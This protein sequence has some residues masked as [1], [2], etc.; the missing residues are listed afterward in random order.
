[1][2][3]SIASPRRTDPPDSASR[4]YAAGLATVL[5][6]VVVALGW[7]GEDW[8]AQLYR[9]ELFR[10]VGFVQWDNGWFGGHYL[11]RYSVLFPPLGGILGVT[12]VVLLSSAAATW[13][14]ADIAMRVLPRRSQ[15]LAIFWFA[16]GSVS[17]VLVGRATFALGLAFALA[18]VAALVRGSRWAIVGAVLASLAS[19][20]AGV[21][22]ALAA[23][24]SW[25]VDRRWL[26]ALSGA[27]ALAPLAVLSVLF[28]EG[29]RF[30]YRGGHFTITL[31]VCAALVLFAPRRWRTLRVGVVLYALAAVAIF[32]V[33]NPLGGNWARLAMFVGGP[34]LAGA[35]WPTRRALFVLLAVPFCIWQWQPAYDSVV[36]GGHDPS[37]RAEYFDPLL[38]FLGR[39]QALRIEIPFT[40]RHWETRY[41]APHVALARGWERQADIEAN[42]IFYAEELR[43]EDYMAWLKDNGVS[44]VALPDVDLDHAAVTEAELLRAGVPGLELVW[45]N[46]NW[47][48]W[49][50]L[51]AR[52]M[53]DGPADL[54]R[55]GA[56]SFTVRLHEPGTALVR[57]RHS[58]H[59]TVDQ[60]GCVAAAANGWTLVSSPAPG[61]LEVRQN[62]GLGASSPVRCTR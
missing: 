14:F 16:V 3:A 26:P 54:V 32:V 18:A 2:T 58:A 50:V 51:D 25:L 4:W 62:I 1:M 46:A 35:L 53:I 47:R 11:P 61:E 10:R 31:G 60:P 5:A 37:S 20:V 9:A 49:K 17:N 48:V 59:W 13:A 8:P 29:G 45:Q 38:D 36:R 43:T 30:P 41:V 21:F 12:P 23:A 52:P 6:L 44:Y 34:L 57:I 15:R 55:V 7:R 19:P 39:D 27:A 42:P 28:P 22:V 33:P 40:E 24:A 56:D